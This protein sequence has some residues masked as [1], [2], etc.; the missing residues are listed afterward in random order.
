MY[1]DKQQLKI[2][3]FGISGRIPDQDEEQF[4]CQA[5]S[6]DDAVNKFRDWIYSDFTKA[7]RARLTKM[8]GEA[9]YI[10]SCFES[11]TP[12]SVRG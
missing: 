3:Y 1:T 6:L 10:T 11:D 4:T 7:K 8:H 9:I 2:K 12:I 5:Y